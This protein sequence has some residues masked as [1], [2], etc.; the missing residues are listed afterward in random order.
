MPTRKY[1]S[2]EA[3]RPVRV[4]RIAVANF[5]SLALVLGF[6]L[7]YLG[8]CTMSADKSYQ[9]KEIGRQ[10]SEL[11]E[12]RQRQEMRLLGLQTMGNIDQQVAELGFVPVEK[13][14]YVNLGGAVAVR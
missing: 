9:I 8:L 12:K 4:D 11:G 1:E 5:V 2:V 6:F 14:S 3:P 7:G 13:V 10:A